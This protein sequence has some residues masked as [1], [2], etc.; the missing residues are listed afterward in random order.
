MPYL[1]PRQRICFAGSPLICF[2]FRIFPMP[3]LVCAGCGGSNQE[4]AKFC[5][6]C[7]SKLAR[8]CPGCGSDNPPRARFCAECGTPLAAPSTLALPAPG[9]QSAAPPVLLDAALSASSAAPAISQITPAA[10]LRSALFADANA[11]VSAA[12]SAGQTERRQITVLFCDLVGSTALAEK[13]DPEDLHL[14]ISAYQDAC[15]TVIHRHD[16]YIAKYLGDGQMVFFGYPRAHEDAAHRALR[17][18]LEMVDAIARLAERVRTQWGVTLAA[19][20]GVHTGL[21]VAGEMGAEDRRVMDIV[22]EAPNIAARLQEVAQPNTVVLSAATRRLTRD[23]FTFKALGERALKGLSRPMQVYQALAESDDIDAQAEYAANVV[24]LVGREREQQQLNERWQQ[25]RAGQSQI[26]LISGEAGIGKTRLMQELRAQAADEADSFTTQMKC[27]PYNQSSAFYPIVQVLQD[28]V[29]K[30]RREDTPV[31]RALKLETFLGERGFD[32]AETAPLLASLLAL[33]PEF[34]APLPNLSAEGRRQKTLEV[35]LNIVLK[36]AARQPYLLLLENAHWADPSTLEMLRLLAAKIQSGAGGNLLLLLTFRPTLAPPFP[37]HPALLHLDLQRLDDVHVRSIVQRLS[38]GQSLSPGV[39]QQ[40]IAKTDGVPLY[41]EEMTKMVLESGAEIGQDALAL[42]HG[43]ARDLDVP[44]TLNDSLMA[45][46]DHL[47]TVK[48]IAQ[49][50]AVIGREFTCELLQAVCRQ[51]RY[52]LRADLARLVAAELLQE[53]RDVDG[54]R[55]YRFKHALIQDAAYK[56]LLISRRQQ[57]HRQ[58]AETLTTQFADV[59]EQQPELLAGHY[60]L[61]GMVEPALACWNRAGQRALAR[62]AN[63]EAAIHFSKSLELLQS[64]PDTPGAAQ[65]ELGAQ[66]SL[67]VALIATQGFA[68]PSVGKVFARAEELCRLFGDAPQTAPVLLGLTGFHIVSGHFDLAHTLSERLLHQ[69]AAWNHNPLQTIGLYMRAT[70]RLWQGELAACHADLDAAL[71]LYD[72]KRH[73]EYTAIWSHDPGVSVLCCLN[74]VSWQQGFPDAAQEYNRRALE[75]AE[76]TGHLFSKA[77]ALNCEALL[78]YWRRE[79]EAAERLGAISVAHSTE[80]NFP[81]FLGA[82]LTY[83]G[84]GAFHQGRQQEGLAR[85]QAG[86]ALYEGIGSRVCLPLIIGMVGEAQGEY[87]DTDGAMQM[88]ERGLALAAQTGEHLAVPYLHRLKGNLLLRQSAQNHDA[89]QECYERSIRLA[90]GLGAKSHELQASMDLCRLLQSR[91][92]SEE[93]RGVLE[94]IHA[95]FTDG[96]TTTAYR[97]A[98]NLLAGL[99]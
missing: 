19:R 53:S 74:L 88:M 59:S 62:S 39:V 89:A 76:Q 99:S 92:K 34:I 96:K 83:Q 56:S 29:L 32:V 27:S 97:E 41:V 20:I 14:L 84:W 15:S 63:Q 8:L 48:E 87:G 9:K 26:A 46:L 50:A 68:S 66:A 4:H 58:I 17:A 55:V 24:P 35:L 2:A 72:V 70:P 28:D 1:N 80:Q 61:A 73:A 93:A 79:P 13:L 57:Y 94:P 38:E 33:P 6:E 65:Q 25:A 18:A 82:S 91:G 71:A 60:T 51:D 11:P 7:G 54:G 78:A 69:G 44:T 49:I 43:G 85:M 75:L 22:G 36:R 98:T 10:P 95:W 67:G 52:T 77:W 30:F 37:P 64:H 21:V 3:E 12:P 45:R 40:I 90:R 31:V 81:F 42:P 47:S 86:L 23:A 5:I 16:G